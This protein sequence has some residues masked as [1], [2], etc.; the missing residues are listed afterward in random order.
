[1]RPVGSGSTSDMEVKMYMDSLPSIIGTPEGRAFTTAVFQAKANIEK[2]VMDATRRW[3]KGEIDVA[4][5]LEINER[6]RSQSIFT[7]ATERKEIE[8]LVPD[9]FRRMTNPTSDNSESSGSGVRIIS[10]EG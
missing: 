10:E 1:M 5:W 8:R 7:T 3:R 6:L 9:F 2:A 4:E